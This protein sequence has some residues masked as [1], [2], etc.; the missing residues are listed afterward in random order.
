[1]AKRRKTTR[2]RSTSRR[3]MTAKQLKYFGPRRAK[4]RRVARRSS[5]TTVRS[6]TTMARRR[7][8]RRATRRRAPTARRGFAFL[9]PNAIAA[10]GGVVGGSVAVSILGPKF[11]GQIP[12]LS[13]STGGRL[14]A[15]AIIG[16]VGYLGLRKFNAT[17]AAGFFAG[18]LAPELVG[19]VNRA[20]A[21]AAQAPATTPA[22]GVNGYLP[23]YVGGV[24]GYLPDY[25]GGYGNGMQYAE[26]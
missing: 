26:I 21:Q 23:D 11:F 13:Q 24:N 22:A 19:A 14:I 15:S 12:S 5:T 17:A 25:T 7:R 16:A 10:V 6:T 2:R 1:M 18:T 20:R 8:S 4:R 9:P 3:R